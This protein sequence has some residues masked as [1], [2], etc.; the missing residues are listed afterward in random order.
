[1]FYCLT[2]LEA[3]IAR[4]KCLQDVRFSSPS[5]PASAGLLAIFGVPWLVKASPQSL[6]HLRRAFSLHVC[7][8]PNSPFY[9]D[10]GNTELGPTLLQYD[11]ILTDYVCK[12]LFPNKVTF[13]GTMG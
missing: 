13:R 3:R 11:F 5:L 9:E 4:S 6:P 7:L 8:S 12:N 1:M 10:T 2:V